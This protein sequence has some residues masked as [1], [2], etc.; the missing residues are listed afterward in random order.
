[1][2]NIKKI[3]LIITNELSGTIVYPLLFHISKKK[4]TRDDHTIISSTSTKLTFGII[5]LSFLHY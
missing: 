1:M 3:I 4:L 5:R 2:N